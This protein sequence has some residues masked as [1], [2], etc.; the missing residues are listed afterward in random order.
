MLRRR[1]IAKT[2]VVWV[3]ACIAVASVGFGYQQSGGPSQAARPPAPAAMP[4]RALLDQYCV[5]CHNQTLKTAGLA[6]DGMDL[7]DIPGGAAT[8]EKSS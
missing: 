7:A 8:W 3:A 2:A 4:G 1:S 6:L 5:S